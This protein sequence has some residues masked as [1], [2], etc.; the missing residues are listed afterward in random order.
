MGRS[1]SVDLT[2][3]P[4]GGAGEG[5]LRVADADRERALELL[6]EHCAQG[7]L[8]FDELSE[9]S[10]RACAAI[11]GAE[12]EAL[13]TDLPALAPAGGVDP[14]V[15]APH[16]AARF[17]LAVMGAVTR[18]GGWRLPLHH[19]A[20]S[21][22]GGI[23]LDLRGAQCD[24]AVVTIDALA[25]MG[26][27]DVVVPD[28]TPVD[29]VGLAVM[30][31]RTLRVGDGPPQPG[32]PLVRVRALAV[33]GSV[34]VRQGPAA[35]DPASAPRRDQRRSRRQARRAARWFGDD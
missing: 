11:T 28:G 30:G 8:T 12:L 25:V 10:A 6:R 17:T 20:A 34:T 31:D 33:M 24:G 27:I 35:S 1:G 21:V 15:W 22:M 18:R 16:R 9:R 23:T 19:I 3:S 26:S 5:A 13:L 32:R 4:G 7:R 14:D 2:G 29:L